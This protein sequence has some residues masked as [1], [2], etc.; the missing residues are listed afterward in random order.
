MGK[1]VASGRPA[2]VLFS[3]AP[4]NVV[5]VRSGILAVWLAWIGGTL[6]AW[7]GTGTRTPVA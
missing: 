2:S 4:K 3:S 1:L 6:T 5:E 7:P